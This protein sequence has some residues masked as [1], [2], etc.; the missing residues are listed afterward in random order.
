M[1]VFQ[2]LSM[3]TLVSEEE[4]WKH[5]LWKLVL[6]YS[7]VFS[8]GSSVLL[9]KPR[10]VQPEGGW[11]QVD[12]TETDGWNLLRK[13]FILTVCHENC[14][15]IDSVKKTCDLWTVTA[16]I[17]ELMIYISKIICAVLTSVQL[18]LCC[19]VKIKLI[20][21][22]QCFQREQQT[23]PGCSSAL[24]QNDLHFHFHQWTCDVEAIFF[25]LR[26]SWCQRDCLK[27]HVWPTLTNVMH[28]HQTWWR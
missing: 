24:V 18:S 14:S 7:P 22:V 13:K 1:L 26:S 5:N 28:L 19:V 25:F 6:S 27:S 17:L 15:D 8:F 3:P 11:G 23:C 2:H 10:W 9:R 21:S 20:D 16:H 12:D 4:E